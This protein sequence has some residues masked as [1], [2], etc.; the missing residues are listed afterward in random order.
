MIMN[1]TNK[2]NNGSVDHHPDN[3]NHSTLETVIIINCVLNA[4][5]MLI[6]ILGNALVL[7]AIMKTPSI[8]STPHVIMLCSLAVSDFLVGLINQPIYIAKQ[9][10]KDRF[11]KHDRV[12]SM[13]SF[14]LDNN[15]HHCGSI[16][17]SSLSHEICYFS[18]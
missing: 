14:F 18:D 3:E 9:L 2:Y 12:F 8:R 4:P 16:S 10:T 6:S 11:V 7:A 5:L 1:N 13:W 17:G 15:S